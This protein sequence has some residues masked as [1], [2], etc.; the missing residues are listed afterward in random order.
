MP[1]G[2][3]GELAQRLFLARQLTNVFAFRHTRTA[4]LLS[5][6]ANRR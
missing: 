2:K 4:D 3:L 6:I 1:L 5:R